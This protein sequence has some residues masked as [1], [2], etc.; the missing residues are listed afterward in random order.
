MTATDTTPTRSA[1][2]QL[3]SVFKLGLMR[4]RIEILSFF[5][6]KQQLVF[7]FLLPVLLLVIFGSAFSSN[8]M[9]GNITFAQYFTAG[10]IAS[11]IVYTAFQNLGIAIPEERQDGT[12][13]RLGGIPMPKLAYFLGKVGQVAFAY[14]GQTAILLIIGR[15]FF[16]VH[17]PTTATQWWTF[18]WISVMGL[19]TWTLLGIAISVV[20]K[21]ARSASAVITPIVL[22]LQFISGVFFVFAQLP[23]WMQDVASIF[24]L[25]WMTQGMRSVFLPDSFKAQEV[26]G[27]WQLGT[28]AI[29]LAIWIV[30]GLVCSIAFFRWIP[31]SQR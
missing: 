14:V 29:M 27:H 5:R 22:V 13:K 11:G 30:I 6:L 15:L 4:A 3:P 7:T 24:P 12:L 18:T 17:L 28:V 21:N 26:G 19:A 31:K 8:K 20:P 10:M 9:P 25:R 16:K 23:K 2:P 1:A